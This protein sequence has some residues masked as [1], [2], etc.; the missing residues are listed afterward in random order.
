VRKLASLKGRERVTEPSEAQLPES[1]E[2]PRGTV[3]DTLREALEAELS[4]GDRAKNGPT[5]G[6][7]AFPAFGDAA[8]GDR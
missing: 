8:F 1:V 3:K 2:Q 6:D 4:E 5:F 7:A